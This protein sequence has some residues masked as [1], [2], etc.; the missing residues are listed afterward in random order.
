MKNDFVS[1]NEL[2]EELGLHYKTLYKEVRKGNLPAVKIG[3]GYK[4]H[5]DDVETY[6]FNKRCEAAGKDPAKVQ[7]VVQFL[8]NQENIPN[9]AQDIMKQ[10]LGG[11]PDDKPKN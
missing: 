9:E 2:S 1:L 5:R 8:M 10:M 3:K 7:D 4:V 11:I 6:V